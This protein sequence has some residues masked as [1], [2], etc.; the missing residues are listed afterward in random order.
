MWLKADD[1]GLSNGANVTT[2]PDSSGN[3][4][5]ATNGS[6]TA[7]TYATSVLNG[8]GVVHITTTGPQGLR[9]SPAATTTFTIIG[10]AHLTST[11]GARVFAGQTDL[12][13]NWLVG[14]WNNTQD[15]SYF[16]GAGNLGGPAATTNWIMYG[17]SCDGTTFNMWSYGTLIHTDGTAIAGMGGKFSL[18]GDNSGASSENSNCEVAEVLICN[19]VASTGDRQLLEGYMAWK[20]GQQASLPG[21]HPYA[22]AAPTI[23]G[24]APARDTHTAVPFTRGAGGGGKI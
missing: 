16:N 3:A 24:G 17:A 23:D 15:A 14:W 21:G 13:T 19:Y 4:A 1:L 9:A 7:P 18:S 22:G 11:P 6:L 8:L 12:A 10:L 20:W 5:D 2:W